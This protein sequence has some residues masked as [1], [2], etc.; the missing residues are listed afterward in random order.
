MSIGRAKYLNQL[1]AIREEKM[2]Y[3]FLN[4]QTLPE[5]LLI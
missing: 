1:D 2:K 5:Q 3:M 4:D